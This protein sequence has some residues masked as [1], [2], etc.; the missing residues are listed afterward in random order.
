MEILNEK[1]FK[2]DPSV[3]ITFNNINSNK[4]LE[5]SKF[6]SND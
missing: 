6:K 2:I 1:I 4:Y 3:N 5:I